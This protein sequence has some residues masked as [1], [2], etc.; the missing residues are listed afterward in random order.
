MKPILALAFLSGSQAIRLTQE[1]DKHYPTSSLFQA[2][3]A[4]PEDDDRDDFEGFGSI[5]AMAANKEAL[6][7]KKLNDPVFQQQVQKQMEAKETKERLKKQAREAIEK[8]QKRDA[9]NAKKQRLANQKAKI[10]AALNKAA[11]K[12]TEEKQE[13]QDIAAE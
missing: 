10:E 6:V 3:S 5:T 13:Q 4:A 9:E 8:A 11:K 1:T 7:N 12:E 2:T